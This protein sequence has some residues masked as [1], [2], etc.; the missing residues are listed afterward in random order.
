M[1][2]ASISIQAV[3]LDAVCKGILRKLVQGGWNKGNFLYTLDQTQLS[4][5]ELS[6]LL[7]NGAVF[8][9]Y[10]PQPILKSY[11]VGKHG[12]D[13]GKVAFTLN[14]DLLP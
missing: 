10:P 14:F 7:K 3:Q 1:G 11:A 13:A 4:E 9:G 8:A 2:N 6:Y 5:S 12:A